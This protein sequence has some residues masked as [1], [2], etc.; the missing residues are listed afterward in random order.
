M[1]SQY[2]EARID[3]ETILKTNKKYI[4]AL[5][6]LAETCMNQARFYRRCQLIGRARDCAQDALDNVTM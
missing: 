2:Q 4:L 3:F 6:G 5:K 1:L